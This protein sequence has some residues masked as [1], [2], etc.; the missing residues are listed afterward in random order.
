MSNNKK[1]WGFNGGHYSPVGSTTN[2]LPAG[3]Y[4]PYSIM[5]N[6]IGVE[7]RTLE[8]DQ[9]V[10]T[11]ESPIYQIIDNVRRFWARRSLFAKLGL[12]HKRGV[13][14][15][16]GPGTGKTCMLELLAKD[17]IADDGIVLKSASVGEVGPAVQ[18]IRGV[19]PDVRIA[20][21]LE[22]ID[23]CMDNDDYGQE[24]YLSNLLD[25]IDQFS[26]I[27]FLATTNH[28]ERIPSRFKNRPSRFDEVVEIG[29][30]SEALRLAFL[31]AKIPG[32]IGSP[33][34]DL[35]K[36]AL[37]SEGFSLAHLRE[38]IVGVLA[39]GRPYDEVL[40]RLRAMIQANEPR[41]TQSQ[42]EAS[43]LVPT[44][45]RSASR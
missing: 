17:I 11:P 43:L 2:T 29:L 7:P 28:I 34:P 5:G 14:V 9:L 8:T 21:V 36:W 27:V 42:Y 6:V 25:G 18:M 30:P 19:E 12:V 23:N 10:L 24:S 31:T 37:D 15:Y 16:G 41:E 35:R 20:V 44:A 4:V 26:N 1:Q 39:L 40:A 33:P 13:L 45:Q 3:V 38:L 22:D 32:N